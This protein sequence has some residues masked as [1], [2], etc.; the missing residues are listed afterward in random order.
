MKGMLSSQESVTC[1]RASFFRKT[2]SIALQQ[3]MHIVSN[4]GKS[5]DLRKCVIL[6][7]ELSHTAISTAFIH[8]LY[9][10]LYIVFFYVH[11][12][13]WSWCFDCYSVSTFLISIHTPCICLYTLL[14][15][16]WWKQTDS[17]FSQHSIQ[18]SACFHLLS[19][20]KMLSR[21]LLGIKYCHS[22]PQ[23]QTEEQQSQWQRFWKCYVVRVP[24]QWVSSLL[25]VA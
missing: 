2:F 18:Y 8:A 5:H 12:T 1:E 3:N 4:W 14:T 24:L 6:W 20:T 9:F 23:S 25:H 7:N 21:R 22:V 19:L 17:L 11:F 15:W 10:W 16:F 13:L